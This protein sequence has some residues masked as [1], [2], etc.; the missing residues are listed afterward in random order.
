MDHSSRQQPKIWKGSQ[1][2]RQHAAKAAWFNQ[3][4]EATAQGRSVFQFMFFI[5][6]PPFSE[7]R[8]QV[9]AYIE[10]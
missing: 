6:V 3:A 8:S 1:S 9:C 4:L 7:R 2:P 10:S 5:F